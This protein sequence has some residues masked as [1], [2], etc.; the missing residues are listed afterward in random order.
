[1]DLDEFLTLLAKRMGMVRRG[2]GLDLSR[3][4]AYF[5]RWWREDGATIYAQSTIS[6]P[7][8]EV[9]EG[10]DFRIHHPANSL[11]VSICCPFRHLRLGL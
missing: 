2:E 6:S 7:F 4:A 5:V 1:M 3:A 9:K 10:P 8:Q 11:L